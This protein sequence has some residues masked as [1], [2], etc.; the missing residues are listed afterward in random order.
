MKQ[1]YSNLIAL[2]QSD[3]Y[4]YYGC[5]SWKFFFKLLMQEKGFVASVSYRAT[6]FFHIN[7]CRPIGFF[8]KLTNRIIQEHYQCEL[9]YNCR[10][11]PGLHISHLSGM[12]IN[13]DC[14]LGKNLNLSHQITLGGKPKGAFS[15]T[16]TLL[17]NIYIGP[18]AKI[19]GGIIIG[20]YVAIG[21]NAVVVKP[22][23]DNC[24]A[25]GVPAKILSEDGSGDYC[26]NT[27]YEDKIQN[28]PSIEF[29]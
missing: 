29:C 3:M 21:A 28:L 19:I 26:L 20:N 25:A 2:I 27:D 4:R 13:G 10:V 7:K 22:L 17:D 5:I 23:P 16:P 14:V 15:G 18:G 9:P 12:V 24:V 11:G 8:M 6:R 1:S